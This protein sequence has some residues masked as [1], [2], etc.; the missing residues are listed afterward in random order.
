M[1]L[2]K[3]AFDTT[4]LT[5]ARIVQVAANFVVLPILSRFLAPSDFGLIALANSIVL[6]A[7]L[8]GD[9][10]IAQSLVR[11]SPEDRDVWSSVFWMTVL[12]SACLA[13]LQLAIA[14]PAAWLLNEPRV[15]W[16]IG[17]LAAGPFLQGIMAAPAADVQQRHQFA[18]LAASDILGSIFGIAGAIILA[19]RG[20]GAWALVAQSL[21]SCGIRAATISAVTHFRPTLAFCKLQVNE[22]L[23]FGRDTAAFSVV[24]FFASQMDTI[25]IGR[26]LGTGPLGLYSMAYRI[27]SA[28]S[29]LSSPI[30]NA[31]YPR[32][33]R[34]RHD[35][36]S[37]RRLLLVV[38]TGLA[39]LIFPPMALLSVSSKSIF[40]VVLSD[41]WLGS[42][43]VFSFL[44]PIGAL[45]A[46]TGIA[47]SFFMAIGRTDLRLRLA[48]E[49][50]LL[51]IVVLI[52]VVPFGIKSV[53]I[54]YAIAHICYYP[55]FMLLYLRLFECR[56]I[57]FVRALSIPTI[58]SL[59][60]ALL[61][62]TLMYYLSTWTEIIMVGAEIIVAYLLIILF[63]RNKLLE[64]VSFLRILSMNSD[65]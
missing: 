11:T 50:T 33:V 65:G 48:T 39:A 55:R 15:T 29:L 23:N 46:V 8:V 54:W 62:E 35:K 20:G 10:G 28:A 56:I 30:Q 17:A 49:F 40:A 4:I 21:I 19:V 51:W 60:V 38:S 36:R 22:H 24:L 31:L 57:T 59:I 61:H 63:M 45:H 26:L 18:W 6:F 43:P 58:V 37:L 64:A 9:P 16:L 34:L 25:L 5:I 12:W 27:M 41:R 14:L 32:M 52:F 42:A 53:A 47:G 1:A 2:K 44:A 7:T 3:W 13:I